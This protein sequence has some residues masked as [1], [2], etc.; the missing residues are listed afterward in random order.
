MRTPHEPVDAPVSGG[1]ALLVAAIRTPERLGEL[2]L[3][4]WERLLAAARRNGL[5]AHLHGVA[6]RAGVFDHLPGPVAQHLESARLEAA[7]IAQL[8]RWELLQV[9][10]RVGTLSTP[11]IALKGAAYLLLQLPFAEGRLVSD[12]DLLVARESIDAVEARLLSGGWTSPKLHPYDQMYYRRWMHELPPLQYPGRLLGVD[13]HHTICPPVSRLKPDP[14]RFLAQS[15]AIP[16]TPW[17][18]LAPAHM[19]LHSAVHLFFD[20][21]FNGRFRDLVDLHELLGRFAKQAGFAAGLVAEA[22]LQGLTRPLHYAVMSLQRYLGT[23]VPDEIVE[24]APRHAPPWPAR[25]LMRSLLDRTL[26][27]IDPAVFPRRDGFPLWALYVRSHWLR[28]PPYLLVPH[29]V[30]KA[31]RRNSEPVTE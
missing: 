28:M 30:R 21:D 31:L 29:L 10:R 6:S 12:V 11:V 18:V 19:F 17:R 20:S 22:E 8:A 1:P 7:R 23:A 3:P 24:W 15:V 27:P 26:P 14:A 13:L 9:E 25:G 16:G 4:A 5:T 2:S